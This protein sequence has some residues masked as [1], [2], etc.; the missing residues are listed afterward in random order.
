MVD[1]LLPQ[2]ATIFVAWSILPLNQTI[3]LPAL[4]PNSNSS[5][6]TFRQ[7]RFQRRSKFGQFRFQAESERRIN[8]CRLTQTG[9]SRHPK[10]RASPPILGWP[11]RNKG[12]RSPWR[13][14]ASPVSIWSIAV[15]KPLQR[16]RPPGHF[17]SLAPLTSRLA[18][19]IHQPRPTPHHRILVTRP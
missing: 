14:H 19:Y 13:A 4:P 7:S 6:M 15:E 11:R 9:L 3:T 16:D 8:F 18:E 10:R 17:A 1:Y 2:S 5:R 12:S